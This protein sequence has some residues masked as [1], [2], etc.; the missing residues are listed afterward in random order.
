[1]ILGAVAGSS[2]HYTLAGGSLTVGGS[3][4]VGSNGIGTFT[5]SGGTHTI[6]GAIVGVGASADSAGRG[7]DHRE[8][9]TGRAELKRH[10]YRKGG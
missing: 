5:Q 8:V 6:T 9:R 10:L 4:R 1:V 7:G 2:G 3:T